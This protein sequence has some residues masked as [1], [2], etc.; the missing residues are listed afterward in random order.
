MNTESLPHWLRQQA[1]HIVQR[2]Q[3]VRQ[4][5][6]RLAAGAAEGF[7]RTKDGLLGLSRA[8][9]DGAVDGARQSTRTDGVL[10]EVV[11]G[12]ADGLSTAAEALKLTLE[13]AKSGGRA[14]A[15][16]DLK[17]A[18]AD[19][20]EIGGQFA[21]AVKT[22][23]KGL[24]AEVADQLHHFSEHAARALDAVKPKFESAIQAAA[25]HPVQAGKEAVQAGAGAARQAAGVLFTELGSRLQQAGQKLRRSE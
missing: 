25:E 22:S 15:E 8:V 10:R 5:I 4:E 3:N 17:K 13:E 24:G 7:H 21:G 1:E 6:S 20:R 14:Y 11:A 12:L 9:L 16:E 2:G 19:F 23:L 18:A